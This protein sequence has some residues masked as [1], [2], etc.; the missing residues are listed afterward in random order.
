MEILGHSEI[1][2]TM[3]TY[4]H[5]STTTARDAV[6]LAEDAPSEQSEG[7]NDE[8]KAAPSAASP[9]GDL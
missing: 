8:V 4:T 7:P 6:D 1:R 5:V 9:H 2:V 3:N